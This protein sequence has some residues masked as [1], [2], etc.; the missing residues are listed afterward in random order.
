MHFQGLSSC[1]T[2]TY[3]QF[4][5]LLTNK[6]LLVATDTTIGLQENVLKAYTLTVNS[7]NN[8]DICSSFELNSDCSL[9]LNTRRQTFSRIWQE[10]RPILFQPHRRCEIPR[11]PLRRALD[12][13]R[14]ENFAIFDRNR[15]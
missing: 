13:W 9:Y 2:C 7:L 8:C 3:K 6:I 15:R 12:T 10:H 11:E 4:C 5:N 14:W 1:I